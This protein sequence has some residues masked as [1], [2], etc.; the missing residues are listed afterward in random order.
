[1]PINEKNII[2]AAGRII[3]NSGL[4]ALS[5]KNLS[6]SLGIDDTM[7]APYI[8]K[9]EDIYSILFDGLE[10]EL[11]DLVNE[12]FNLDPEPE[13][14]LQLLFKRLFVLF[15]EKAFYL[16]IIF[17]ESHMENNIVFQKSVVR[18][19]R[20][21]E[22]Y[23]FRLIEEGKNEKTF[24]TEKPTKALVNSI[25]TGFRLFMKDEQKI[26]NMIRELKTLRKVKD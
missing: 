18:I 4:S 25:L 8:A 15:R 26:N 7:L 9:D 13:Q 3:D 5:I 2:E 17:G 14:A 1:M 10:E 6:L 21:A 24:K 19:K 11:N 22:A 16:S 12:I 23:L 20:I